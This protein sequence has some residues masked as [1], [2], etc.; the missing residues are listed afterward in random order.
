MRLRF[1]C[2]FISNDSITTQQHVKLLLAAFVTKAQSDLGCPSRNKLN[3]GS[4]RARWRLGDELDLHGPRLVQRMTNALH[5]TSIHFAGLSFC[6]EKMFPFISFPTEL[7]SPKVISPVEYKDAQRFGPLDLKD[8][9][10]VFCKSNVLWTNLYFFTATWKK[11]ESYLGSEAWQDEHLCWIHTCLGNPEWKWILKN[12]VRVCT[13]MLGAILPGINFIPFLFLESQMKTFWNK[14]RL[15]DSGVCSLK[16]SPERQL[17]FQD[18]K[19]GTNS[20]NKGPHPCSCTFLACFKGNSSEA[21]EQGSDRH[22]MLEW[23]F[24]AHNCGSA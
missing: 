6:L 22:A 11:L 9:L 21:Y 12:P 4:H 8:I 3:Q 16:T 14:L 19:T 23:G 10:V 1:I 18:T 15:W 5:L 20:V 24:L 13:C 17:H 2:R 7:L